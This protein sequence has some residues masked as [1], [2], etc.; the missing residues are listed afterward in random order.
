MRE[1]TACGSTRYRLF[2]VSLGRDTDVRHDW[3]DLPMS[4]MRLESRN[5]FLKGWSDYQKVDEPHLDL[6]GWTCG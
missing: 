3:D 4:P 6:S 1:P 2:V 5:T